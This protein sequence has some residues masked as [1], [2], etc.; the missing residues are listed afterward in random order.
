MSQVYATEPQTTGRV[1]LETSHGPIDINLWCKECPTTTRMFLQLC[2]DGYYESVV[3]HRIMENFLIQAGQVKF[4][5]DGKKGGTTND[6]VTEAD[7]KRYLLEQ[8]STAAESS[9][10]DK[11][12]SSRRKLEVSPRIRF[13]H[14]G[15]VAL[16]L[17]LDEDVEGNVS[18][19][20]LKRQFF[21]TLEE[22]SF[23]DGKHVIFGTVVGP[24]VFNAI[25]IGKV[26]VEEDTSRPIDM[27][28]SPPII[29]NVKIDHHPFQDMVPTED[30]KTPWKRNKGTR[31]GGKAGEESEV[32]KRRK[33]RKG[34]RDLNVLSFG[35]EMTYDDMGASDGD[36]LVG[37]RSSHD[38]LARGSQYASSSVDHGEKDVISDEGSKPV[39]KRKKGDDDRGGGTA[40]T[41]QTSSTRGDSSSLVKER[42][43]DR[44]NG[45]GKNGDQASHEDKRHASVDDK[46]VIRRDQKKSA[47][48]EAS[49]SKADKSQKPTSAVEARRAKYLKRGSSRKA[50]ATKDKSSREEDTIKKLHSFRNKVLQSKGLGGSREAQGGGNNSSVVDNSLAARMA[51]RNEANQQGAEDDNIALASAYRGQVLQDADE[52]DDPAAWLNSQFKCRK[53][54]DHVTKEGTRDEKQNGG[55]GRNVDDY[56]VMDSK[57]EKDDDFR[58]GGTVAYRGNSGR[59]HHF[60]AGGSSGGGGHHRHKHHRKHSRK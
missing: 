48:K 7:M 23:L 38:A 54:I 14:R 3:F 17:P 49:V 9:T 52:E 19:D 8:H 1:I 13:N 35:E 50:G 25:R 33:K 26:A 22:S 40:E 34:K 20:A 10:E 27:D 60:H 59:S 30:S 37:M 29:K 15:Q 28:M 53:H 56:E 11:N 45:N 31:S 21:I 58:G 36:G 57:I 46:E 32:K 5:G 43:D 41:S 44:N 18:A 24:T 2:L 6:I 51:K 42:D 47:R 55:D 16:A 12:Q 4:N 39:K